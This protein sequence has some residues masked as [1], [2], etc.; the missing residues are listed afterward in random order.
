M[1]P[2]AMFGLGTGTYVR[3]QHG[4][5]YHSRVTTLVRVVAS[6]DRFL[7]AAASTFRRQA[8]RCRKPRL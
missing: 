1:W 4:K 3:D 5:P 2:P 6:P 7:V 8:V